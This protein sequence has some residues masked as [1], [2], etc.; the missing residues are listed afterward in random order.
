MQ[1]EFQKDAMLYFG[2]KVIL[3]DA[4]H[5]T[6]QYDFLLISVLVADSHGEGIPVSW[7][8]SNKEDTNT[9]SLFLQAV[10]SR[11]GNFEIECFMSDCAELYFNAWQCTFGGKNTRKLLCI[12]HVDRAWRRALNDHVEEQQDKIEIYH[13]LYVLLQEREENQFMVKLQ[14]LMSFLSDKYPDFHQYFNTQYVAKVKEW[15]TCFRIG[16]IVNTNMFVES[17]HCLL[18]VN[19]LN[20]KQNCRVDTLIYVLLRIARNLIYEQ[21]NKVEK[22]KITHRKHEINKRH[23]SA[24]DIEKH[25]TLHQSGDSWRIESSTTTGTFYFLDRLKETCSCELHCS[26]CDVCIHM[27]M[28]TCLDATLHNTVCKHAHLLHMLL[29]KNAQS[30]SSEPGSSRVV[31]NSETEPEEQS[32]SPSFI[33]G[34]ELNSKAESEQNATD[35]IPEIN[36]ISDNDSPESVINFEHHSIQQNDDHSGNHKKFNTTEYFSDL[37]KQDTAGNVAT[38]KSDAEDLTHRLLS[39][40]QTSN[41]ADAMVTV[42]RHLNS[43]ISIMESKKHYSSIGNKENFNPTKRIPANSNHKMQTR[44]FSTKKKR[45]PTRRT[46]SKPTTS[47]HKKMKLFMRT[48]PIKV[49]GICWK[50]DDTSTEVEINWV[51]CDNCGLWTH[52]TCLPPHR[53]NN[54]DIFLCDSCTSCAQ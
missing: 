2:K 31:T 30:N 46:V 11:I 43:S 42:K 6:T 51:S 8:I 35:H 28:C 4:T 37:L 9:I 41:D 52:V 53:T 33:Q 40:I 38:L 34:S 36:M 16:T 50:E 25:S 15:A 21:L 39:L 54:D 26:T 14:Q 19:Y 1:T 32:E 23:K 13:Q 17:F 49:C 47:E 29:S 44:F 3:M 45:K 24:L 27:Y 48:T 12:W 10:H 7:A 22:N 20:K 18:K 5:G